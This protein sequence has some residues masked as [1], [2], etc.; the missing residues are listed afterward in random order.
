[1]NFLATN[2]ELLLVH[3]DMP[4]ISSAKQ[5]DLMLTPQFYTF[6]KEPLPVKYQYQAIKLAPSIL[7]E[8]TGEGEYSY[9][10]I[11]EN[12]E[13]VLVAYDIEKIES[14]LEE[15][16]LGKSLIGQ[17]Y[18]VQQSR[19]YFK[20]PVAVDDKGALIT[21]EGT[22]VML[23]RSIIE[24]ENLG[25]F[26][27]SYRPDKG[28]TSSRGRDSFVTQKQAIAA[29]VLMFLM[30]GGY[31]AEGLRYKKAI[32]AVN[33][34]VELTK[35]KYPKL[36]DKSSMVLNSIYESDYAVDSI[37]RKLRDRLKEISKLTS[38]DSKIDNLKITTKTYEAVIAVKKKDIS[39]LKKYAKSKNLITQETKGGLKLKGAL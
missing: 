30:A 8:L 36:Q 17:I 7:E 4:Y 29:S 24:T 18:F 27:D 38:K 3:K 20:H 16:G 37:Q 21:V 6:K 5:Y 32:T 13:W 2:N 35:S 28:F 34:K 39:K 12:D 25:K 11:R 26:A 10:A 19:E 22:V 14:F 31:I 23:P 9:A 1:M 15:K 33:E